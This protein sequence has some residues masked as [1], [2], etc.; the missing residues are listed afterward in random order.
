MQGS[1]KHGAL[2]DCTGHTPMNGPC[3]QFSEKECSRQVEEQVQKPQEGRV[4]WEQAKKPCIKK[5][6]DS[7]VPF[8]DNLIQ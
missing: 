7:W 2:Y 8:L 5:H 1:S 4:L 3:M 6:E